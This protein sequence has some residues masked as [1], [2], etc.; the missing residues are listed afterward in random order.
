MLN[1]STL[2]LVML[3]GGAG[4]VARLAVTRLT[5][6][7]LGS[8]FPWGTLMVNFSGAFLAGLMVGGFAAWLGL[9]TGSNGWNILVFGFLG[10]YTTVSS[11]SLEWLLLLRDGRG[12]AAWLYL[13]LT[14]L[15]GVV[16]ALG[17]LLLAA[18][19]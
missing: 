4:A 11:L 12:S 17:G 8:G 16:L 1:I 2:M 5:L 15:G 10:S 13:G 7:L 14:L 18:L 6:S 19:L 9:S 3:A